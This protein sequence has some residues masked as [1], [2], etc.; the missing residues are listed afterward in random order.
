MSGSLTAG[1]ESRSGELVILSWH[2]V[3]PSWFFPMRLGEGIRRLERQLRVLRQVA[4][5]VPLQQALAD[6]AAR[7]PRG[8]R[9]VALTFDD[10]YRDNLDDAVPLLER[11]GLPATFFLV[12]DLLSR[13]G[14][15]WWEVLAW[16]F[17]RSGRARLRWEDEDYQLSSPGPRRLALERV[18]QRLKWRDGVAREAALDELVDEL[19]PSGSARA[20]ELFLDWEG[21]RALV[22]RGFSVGSHSMRH[23]IL[24]REH[25]D[26]QQRDLEESRRQLEAALHVPVTLLA[27]PNGTPADYDQVTIDAAA[28]AGY[29][30]ALTTMAGVNGSNTPRFELRRYVLSPLDSLS[31]WMM[32][33]RDVGK[34]A[35]NSALA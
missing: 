31:E 22:E 25:Q 23:R 27:Y 29:T 34:A 32:I 13:R 11:L 10:G 33:L 5:I 16:A 26:E 19:C 6:L 20:D 1:A 15:P 14:R 18:A 28:R 21:A 7:R 17:A 3:Q 12:P 9:N 8:A 4:R 35:L 2:N 24:S 30:H